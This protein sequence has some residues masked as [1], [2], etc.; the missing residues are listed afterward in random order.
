[1]ANAGLKSNVEKR[2]GLTY[3]VL[4]IP[5]RLDHRFTNIS[6]G[7]KVHDRTNPITPN[8]LR[9]LR[10][11]ANVTLLKGTPPYCPPVTV[12]QIVICNWNE[13]AK[14]HRF[15]CMATDVSRATGN[16]NMTIQINPG[17]TTA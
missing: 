3:I 15:G 4:K 13:P 7:S 8:R 1:M 9:K 6:K 10:L 2:E 5:L 16:Q 17:T 11:I 12:T 14:S